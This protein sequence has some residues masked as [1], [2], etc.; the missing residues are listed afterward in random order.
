MTSYLPVRALTQAVYDSDCHPQIWLT[1]KDLTW[2]PSSTLLE[3]EENAL[4]DPRGEAMSDPTARGR[5]LVINQVTTSVCLDAADVTHDDNFA[6]VL[7]SNIHVNVSEISNST[8]RYGNIKSKRGNRVDAETLA[9]RWN[10]DPAKAKNTIKRTTQRGVRSLMHPTHLRRFSTN[11]RM[12]RYRRMPDPVF[13]DTLKAG[14]VSERGNKYAQVYCTSYGWS[15]AHP[16]KTKGEAHETL[17]LVFSRDGVPPKIVMDNAREQIHGEFR[18]KAKE[19]D[20]AVVSTEPYSPW[21]NLAEGCVR[22]TKKGSSRKMIRKGSPKPLWDHCLELEALIRSKTS[23]NIYE[24]MGE[25]PETRMTGQTA[26]ISNI[27]EYEW[28]DWVM[29]HD[30]PATY[31]EDP[32]TLGR[33]LGPSMDGLRGHDI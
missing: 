31:P 11:D 22:E 18:R 14:T 15:R 7:E 24:L 2:D 12:L 28:Y 10:I 23:H 13:T 32:M 30:S 27:C 21:S 1:S 33:W 26:D 5:E 3:E 9:R 19:A 16:M 4:A 17:S 8:T 20:C 25:V 29:F 6:A